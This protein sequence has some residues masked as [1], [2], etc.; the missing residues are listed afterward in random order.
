MIT[1]SIQGFNSV[2]IWPLSHRTDMSFTLE[3]SGLVVV[4]TETETQ[5]EVEVDRKQTPDKNDVSCSW[6]RRVHNDS[7][8][9]F[10]ASFKSAK[11]MVANQFT[12]TTKWTWI[13]GVRWCGN[14][15]FV[16]SNY[17]VSWTFGERRTPSATVLW[18][19]RHSQQTRN[20]HSPFLKPLVSAH[21]ARLQGTVTMSRAIWWWRETHSFSIISE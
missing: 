1:H 19:T 6:P 16:A 14:V 13:N 8:D 17:I 20:G 7:A 10:V 4:E 12:I 2:W 9:H 11:S 18:K 3:W 5:T 21:F 15:S